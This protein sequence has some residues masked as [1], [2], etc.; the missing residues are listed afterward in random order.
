MNTGPTRI[1][2]IDDEELFRRMLE[3]QLATL[4]Y[5]S[6]TAANGTEGIQRAI[7]ELPDIVLLD[8]FMPE[9]DGIAVCRALRENSETSHIPILFLTGDYD[10]EVKLRCLEAGANDLIT[11]PIEPME[12]DIRIRN[13]VSYSSFVAVSKENRDLTAAKEMMDKARQEWEDTFDSLEDIITI[14]DLDHTIVKANRTAR[15]KLNLTGGLL[16]R[17]KCYECY[18]KTSQ[19]HA[20]CP[21]LACVTTGTTARAELF[22]ESL[23]GH[24]EV[25]AVPRK[26]CTGRITGYIHIVRDISLRKK[27]ETKL[28]IDKTRLKTLVQL[29]RMTDATVDE[30]SNF[31]LESAV[32]LTESAG[33]YL[34]FMNDEDQTLNL[35]AWSSSVR[36]HCKAESVPHYPLARAG[37]WADCVRIKAPVIH[38]DYPSLTTRNGLPAGHFPVIR[39]MSVPVFEGERVVAVAGFGNKENPYTDEDVQQISLFM[40]DMWQL[41]KLRRND[42]AL[43]K[44]Q[45]LLNQKNDELEQALAELKAMQSQMLHQEKMAS[46]GQLA[47]GVAHE[48]NNPTGFIM[49]NLATMIKYAERIRD[50]HTILDQAVEELATETAERIRVSRK[51]LKI[52]RVMTDVPQLI[53]ESLEGA[54]RIKKIVQDLKGF[55]RLDSLD[56]ECAD[57]N[58][59]IESTVNIVWNEL[60]Y[61]A[62]VRKNYGELPKIKCNLG[63]MNQVFM[64]ILVNAAHAIS[65]RGE[66]EIRSWQDGTMAHVAISDTGCGI[67]A[68][69]LN[70]IFEPFFTTKEVGKGTGLGLSIA[71]DIVK[72]HNGSINVVSEV[73]TG[74]TFTVSIP[75]TT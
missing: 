4:G 21:A 12:L 45:L 73:G 59:G 2:I 36:A 29:S 47:A 74:S 3:I 25:T 50:Y 58:A 62:T 51:E 28:R 57:L 9:P 1:L 68:N 6:L 71:Y 63:Q 66:I 5:T 48:I 20:D 31:A 33:G 18:H 16:P 10:R 38:N 24:V 52:N 19:P 11:K 7:T 35:N 46:I 32:Q 22:E 8:V 55:S 43:R 34:H 37:I 53:A 72:K 13:L 61:K 60:K 17:L 27:A 75:L 49:S 30:I 23:N 40:H 65:D 26:D 64:N 41:I 56:M 54:E 67:P 42:E 15:K 39:H 69:K 44:K 14:H 70:R